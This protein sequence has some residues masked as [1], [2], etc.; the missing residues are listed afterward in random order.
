MLTGFTGDS[1]APAATT[2]L[3]ITVGEE[4]RSKTLLVS[5]IV[6]ALP[7]AY[8]AIIG[9]PTLNK[10]KA[11]VL[12]YHRVMKFSTRARVGKSEATLGNPDSVI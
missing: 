6:V 12:T 9:R 1:V 10:L 3:P 11:V 8:N 7:S 5:F 4:P 2:V